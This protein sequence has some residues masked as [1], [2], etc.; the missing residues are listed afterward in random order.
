[1]LATLS[2]LDI[3]DTFRNGRPALEQVGVIFTD[4]DTVD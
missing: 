2:H 4:S 1:M 3:E